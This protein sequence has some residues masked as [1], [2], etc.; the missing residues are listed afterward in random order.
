MS[1]EMKRIIYFAVM[2]II[3][4]AAIFAYSGRKGNGG[5]TV[6]ASGPRKILY[7]HDPMHPGYKSDKPG[8][9]PD[10]GMELVAV[11]EDSAPATVGAKTVKVSS[12]EQEL[13]GVRVAPVEKA[14]GTYKLH[15]FGRVMVDETRIYKLN[16]GIE[17]FIQEVAPSAAA[18]AIVKKDQALAT[19]SAPNAV[20]AMQ[21]FLLNLGAEDRFK[22]SAAE[23]SPEAQSMAA[24]N[25]NIQQ[26]IQQLRNIGMSQS[27]IAEM[28]R[29]RE[30]PETIK[31][32]SPVNGVILS[33]DVSVGQRFDR[34]S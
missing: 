1:G 24:A 21:T 3:V 22:K 33:R 16:A 20:M 4:A 5:S 26:R 23:G 8:I 6:N 15:L 12:E 31:I 13:I 29:V 32:A 18:G 27:Q 28:R 19:F 9:A 14:S 30:V 25:A 7:F 2:L 17:G 11:Y 10:C 34:G